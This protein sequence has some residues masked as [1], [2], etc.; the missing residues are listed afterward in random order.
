[1]IYFKWIYLLANPRLTFSTFEG[2]FLRRWMDIRFDTPY[3]LFACH[4]FSALL[5]LI[6]ILI[7]IF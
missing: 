5:T 4:V 7:C 6:D 2:L 1:M 3:C